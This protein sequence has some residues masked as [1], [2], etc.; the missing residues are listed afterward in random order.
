LY[1][2]AE[3]ACEKAECDSWMLIESP[4]GEGGH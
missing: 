4:L 2:P 3:D 1:A